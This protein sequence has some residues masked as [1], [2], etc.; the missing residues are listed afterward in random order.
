MM[1]GD[2]KRTRLRVSGG[3]TTAIIVMGEKAEQ[4]EKE[5]MGTVMMGRGGS[6]GVYGSGG[7]D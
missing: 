5:V 7:R 2:F 6:G 4:E 3:G 1:Y